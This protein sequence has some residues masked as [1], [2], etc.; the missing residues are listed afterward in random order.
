MAW[1]SLSPTRQSMGQ[2]WRQIQGHMEAVLPQGGG[3]GGKKG[4]KGDSKGGGKQG[5]SS[6]GGGSSSCWSHGQGR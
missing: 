1:P 3:K 2:S 4:K 6:E 5:G